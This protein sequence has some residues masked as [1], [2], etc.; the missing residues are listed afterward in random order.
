MRLVR[1][2]EMAAIDRQTIEEVGLPGAVL[3]E[4]AGQQAAERFSAFMSKAG[5]E[6]GRRVLVLCGPGN[7]GG[8]GLVVGRYLREAGW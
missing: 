7:N 1:G 3:M 2:A 5:S 8:D 6:R 4:R